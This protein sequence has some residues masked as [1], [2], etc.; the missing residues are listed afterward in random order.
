MARTVDPVRHEERRRSILDAATRLLR[1]RGVQGLTIHDVLGEAGISK[2]ALYHYFSGK[3][4]LLAALIARRLDAWSDAVTDTIAAVASPSERLVVLVRTLTSAKSQDLALLVSALPTLHSDDGA[5]LQARL[6]IAGR[7]RFVPL[8][9]QVITDGAQTGVFAAPSPASAARV[10]MSLL[11]EMAEA[12]ARGLREIRDGRGDA[13][14]LH[15]DALAYAAAVPAVLD[16][17]ATGEDFLRPGDLDAWIR[18]AHQLGT[19]SS[20]EQG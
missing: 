15:A 3:D 14:V 6:R 17:P 11:Q 18:A 5:A 19:I 4:E 7:E 16:A 9:T 13:D 1:E 12:V 2:G 10:V 20:K 8:L